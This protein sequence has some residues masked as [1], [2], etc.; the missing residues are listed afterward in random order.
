MRTAADDIQHRDPELQHARAYRE[1]HRAPR[2]DSCRVGVHIARYRRLEDICPKAMFNPGSHSAPCEVKS[3][4]QTHF[5]T[6]MDACQGRLDVE[7]AACFD[8]SRETGER[9]DL[10][11]KSIEERGG[12][13]V[14]T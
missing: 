6:T 10:A 5:K 11:R 12:K 8:E 2:I 14:H 9:L 3:S 4:D 1:K 13:D 7:W